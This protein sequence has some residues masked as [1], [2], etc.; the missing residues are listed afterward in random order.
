MLR[1]CLLLL[2]LLCASPAAW[3]DASFEERLAA[4]D[5]AVLAVPGDPARWL[6]R[7]ALLR[8]EGQPVP[9]LE[10]LDRAAALGAEPAVVQR[11]RGAALL[12]AGRAEE[13]VTALRR[14]L[15]SGGEDARSHATLAAALRS[16]GRP[17]EA[18]AEYGRAL[19]LAPASPA[20]PDWLLGRARALVAAGDT[21]GA[22]GV[23]DA[24]RVTSGAIAVLDREALAIEIEA[25]RYD[26]A[27]ERLARMSQAARRTETFELRRGEILERAGRPEEAAHA[28][29]AA[30]R[31]VE[32]L[33]AERRGAP[34]VQRL[35]A[36]ANHGLERTRN[37]EARP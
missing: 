32:A 8:E 14:G 10:A 28:Y 12:D 18:A 13:A 25:K 36:T 17:R 37:V 33:P 35:V 34:I 27:L 6:E 21:E 31:A 23:L 7:A 5:A 3:A 4:S 24:G 15:A 9:A 26:A 29:A 22:L 19:L 20:A 1:P 30:L 16:V 2:V 11:A